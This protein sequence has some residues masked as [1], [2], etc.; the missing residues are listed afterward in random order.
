[1]KHHIK[2]LELLREHKDRRGDRRRICGAI[3]GAVFPKEGKEA[4]IAAG[5]YALEQSGDTMKLSVPQGF[6]PREW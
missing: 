4:T 1:V 6:A 3:A 2:R 5:L